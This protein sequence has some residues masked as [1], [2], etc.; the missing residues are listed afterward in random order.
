MPEE[1]TETQIL[2]LK[3]REALFQLYTSLPQPKPAFHEWF[4]GDGRFYDL[5]H[6]EDVEEDE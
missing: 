2:L 1:M 3:A 6:P 4:Y 5:L